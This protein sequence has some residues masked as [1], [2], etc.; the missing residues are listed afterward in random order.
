MLD[1][2]QIITPYHF[3]KKLEEPDKDK[4]WTF[5]DE[6]LSASS[7][8][9]IRY[10]NDLK[11]YQ[12]A[13]KGVEMAKWYRF[14]D[15]EPDHLQP[16]IPSNKKGVQSIDDHL[17]DFIHFKGGETKFKYWACR[18]Q[19]NRIQSVFDYHQ[20][21]FPGWAMIPSSL[22]MFNKKIAGNNYYRVTFDKWFFTLRDEYE[23]IDFE[24][25]IENTTIELIEVLF[26]TLG[27]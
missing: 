23:E 24:I 18:L 9:K 16:I 3:G 11:H 7:D 8:G 13:T 6:L 15:K 17:Y 5:E 1:K 19:Y 4:Y 14:E 27:L 26:K 25:K 20:V 12:E 21:L 22:N 10:N 2:T